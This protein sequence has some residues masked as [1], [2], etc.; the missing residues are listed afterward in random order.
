MQNRDDAALWQVT[1]QCGWRVRGAKDVVV[2]AVQ[3]HGRSTHAL[4]LTEAQVMQQAVP[5]EGAGG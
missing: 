1:C 5:A 4:E 3:E 2:T